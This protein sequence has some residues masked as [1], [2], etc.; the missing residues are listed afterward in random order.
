MNSLIGLNWSITII[1]T[2][3]THANPSTFMP[4][5]TLLPITQVQYVMFRILKQAIS[6]ISFAQSCIHFMEVHVCIL[7]IVLF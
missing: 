7:K 4:P 2:G 1:H 5:K 6:D 3:Y